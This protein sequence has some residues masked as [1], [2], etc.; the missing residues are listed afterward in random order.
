[1]DITNNTRKRSK[2]GQTQTRERKECTRAGDLIAE[3]SG[4]SKSNLVNWSTTGRQNPKNYQNNPL[5][6]NQIAITTLKP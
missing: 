2:T 4:N 6:L 5:K 3:V 1:T